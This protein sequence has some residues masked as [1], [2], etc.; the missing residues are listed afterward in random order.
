MVYQPGGH[1]AVSAPHLPVTLVKS[2]KE[3]DQRRT[4]FFRI[5]TKQ[6]LNRT[7][8]LPYPLFQVHRECLVYRSETTA[9]ILQNGDGTVYISPSRVKFPLK[10]IVQPIVSGIF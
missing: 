4:S 8:L 10:G 2:R 7:D 3:T 9:A 1:T 5:F 6:A